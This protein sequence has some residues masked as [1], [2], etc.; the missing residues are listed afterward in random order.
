VQ[1]VAPREPARA[2]RARARAV[3]IE[4]AAEVKAQVL[5]LLVDDSAP[6]KQSAD[7][8]VCTPLLLTLMPQAVAMDYDQQ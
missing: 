2:T 1:E 6:I 3:K 8:Y 4:R 7:V 5:T